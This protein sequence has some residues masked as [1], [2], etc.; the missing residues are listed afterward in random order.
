MAALVALLVPVFYLVLKILGRHLRPLAQQLQQAN[1][2][3]VAIADENLGMLP[4]IKTF[5]RELQESI[6]YGTQISDVRQLSIRQQGIYAILEPTVQFIAASAAVLLLWL[7]SGRIGS[8]QM[9]P[10]E[11]AN[12]LWPRSPQEAAGWSFDQAAQVWTKG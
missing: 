9:N 6:R 12:R 4:A 3:A 5:T 1:A 8:G 10:A 7:A 11:L 2:T